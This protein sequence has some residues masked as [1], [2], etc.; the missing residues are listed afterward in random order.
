MWRGI[1]RNNREGVQVLLGKIRTVE[2]INFWEV[3]GIFM[4]PM[5]NYHIPVKYFLEGNGFSGRIYM[6]DARIV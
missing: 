3:I 4:N 1:I 5:G 6:V 2:R